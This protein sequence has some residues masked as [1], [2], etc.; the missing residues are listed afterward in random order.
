MDVFGFTQDDFVAGVEFGGAA[1]FLS[2]ARRA[3]VTLFV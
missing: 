2:Q 3:H 1:A